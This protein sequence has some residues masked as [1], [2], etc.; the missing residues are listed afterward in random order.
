MMGPIWQALWSHWRRAPLQLVAV[1]FGLALSTALWSGVQAINAEARA[2]Y[3]AA[4]TTLGEGRYDQILPTA[5][6]SFDQASY[7]ALRRAGWLVSPVVEG[8]WPGA[9]DGPRLRV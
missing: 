9:A 4:A 1:V 6:D 8:R 7:I 5:G 2:S 3:D